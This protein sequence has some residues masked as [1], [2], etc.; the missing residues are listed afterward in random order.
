MVWVFFFCLRNKFMPQYRIHCSGNSVY[1]FL[2]WEMRGLSPNFHIHV[3]VNDLYFPRIS[4]NTVFPP[5]EKA[6]PTWEYII[7]S[8]TYGCG[9]WD[10]DTS[11]P[12]SIYLGQQMTQPPHDTVPISCSKNALGPRYLPCLVRL[13]IYIIYDFHVISRQNGALLLFTLYSTFLVPAN[14]SGVTKI[15][16]LIVS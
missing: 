5:A 7:R 6:D 14:V 16:N 2:F 11:R 4:L 1:I 13:L 9:N 8:Q 10:W 12:Q 3:S 15:L